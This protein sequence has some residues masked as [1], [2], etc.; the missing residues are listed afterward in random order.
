LSRAGF[1]LI[2]FTPLK[3]ARWAVETVRCDSAESSMLV[4]RR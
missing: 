3:D 2:R 1:G 4:E